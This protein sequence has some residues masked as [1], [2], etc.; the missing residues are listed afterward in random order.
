MAGVSRSARCRP[1][2]ESEQG[3][4][5]YRRASAHDHDFSEQ[6]QA[7]RRL[8]FTSILAVGLLH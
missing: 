6:P 5:Y 7:G 3:N 1:L 2:D 8:P 4:G